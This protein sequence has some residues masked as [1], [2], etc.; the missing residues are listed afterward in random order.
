M[1][2]L[3]LLLDIENIVQH[4]D[5]PK[6]LSITVIR[7]RTE[8]SNRLK[9]LPN[10]DYIVNDNHGSYVNSNLLVKYLCLATVTKSTASRGFDVSTK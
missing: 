1:H 9:R 3:L 4:V 8:K 10:W 7:L 5:R 6:Y 2:F